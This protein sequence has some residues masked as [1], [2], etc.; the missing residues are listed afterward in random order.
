MLRVHLAELRD[1]WSAWLGVAIAFVVINASLANP[2]EILASGLHATRTGQLDP[3]SSSGYTASQVL[4]IL[5]VA[6][7]AGP[8][9]GSVTGLVVDS[10]RGSLA[11]LALAG[12]TPRQIRGTVLSQLVAVSL[13][14]AVVGDALAAALTRPSLMLLAYNQRD[15][16]Y[17]QVIDVHWSVWP[18]LGANLLC[19]LVALLGGS[20]HARRASLTPPVEALRQA[21][22]PTARRGLGAS[23]WL[24]AIVPA[25]AIIGTY[26]AIA[27]IITYSGKESISNLIILDAFQI[28]LWGF[29]LAALAPVL[30]QPATRAW[31]RLVPSTRSAWVLA[32]STVTARADRMRRSITPVMFAVGIAVAELGMGDSLLS[33]LEASGMHLGLTTGDLGTFVMIAGPPLAV[34]LA[35]SIGSLI[36]MSRQRDAELALLGIAGATPGQRVTVPALEAL[37]ITVSAVLLSLGMIVPTYVY[38]AVALTRAGL[39]WRGSVPWVTALAVVAVCALITLASTVLP[40]LRARR[41]PENRVIARLVAE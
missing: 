25:L 7:V 35:G 29:L 6:L 22:A 36:M 1:S 24:K 2:A 3:L 27:P 17:F 14:C 15:E 11:R 9:I 8:V 38:Q 12:A 4:M 37:I 33:S 32:R 30:V 40:T 28:F 13:A 18:F 10:R 19:V 20:K 39:T 23:G 5:M 21:T 41:L 16:D 26:A 34:A 31:T